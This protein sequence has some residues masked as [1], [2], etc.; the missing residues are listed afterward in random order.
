M[1]NSEAVCSSHADSRVRRRKYTQTSRSKSPSRPSQIRSVSPPRRRP[2]RERTPERQRGELNH[3]S[4][5]RRPKF[6][7]SK[8]LDERPRHLYQRKQ[9]EFHRQMS[10]FDLSKDSPP[11][12]GDNNKKSGKTFVKAAK[13]FFKDKLPGVPTISGNA[14]K[15]YSEIMLSRFRSDSSAISYQCERENLANVTGIKLSTVE[16]SSDGNQSFVDREEVDMDEE[17]IEST[18]SHELES[19]FGSHADRLSSVTFSQYQH[20]NDE[21][22]GDKDGDDSQDDNSNNDQTNKFA[23]ELVFLLDENESLR[24]NINGLRR[25]FESMLKRM[26]MIADGG[27]VC[28]DEQSIQT[29]DN[30]RVSVCLR[31]IDEMKIQALDKFKKVAEKR[32]CDKNEEFAKKEKDIESF[33]ECIEDLLCENERLFNNVVLL[34]KERETILKEVQCLRHEIKGKQDDVVNSAA[35]LMLTDEREAK[36]QNSYLD[37]ISVLLK[38][39]R[40]S[41]KENADPTEVENDIISL[42]AKIMTQ[43]HYLEKLNES[44]LPTVPEGCEQ[45]CSSR[46]AEG[47][48]EQYSAVIDDDDKREADDDDYISGAD[49]D[50]YISGADDDDYISGAEDDNHISGNSTCSDCKYDSSEYNEQCRE[51]YHEVSSDSL[52]DNKSPPF[53]PND[54]EDDSSE[55]L[56]VI[57]EYYSSASEASYYCEED[58]YYPPRRSSYSTADYS[59][60][61]EVSYMF[62]LYFY[63]AFPAVLANI[64]FFSLQSTICLRGHGQQV[65]Q[66]VPLHRE[67]GVPLQD[68]QGLLRDHDLCVEVITLLHLRFLLLLLKDL[69]RFIASLSRRTMRRLLEVSRVNKIIRTLKTLQETKR[70]LMQSIVT[71]IQRFSTSL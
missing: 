8:S 20:Q 68:E 57:Y 55:A 34:S 15:K 54:R 44:E 2:S 38:K 19:G 56:E 22:F 16:H 61:I 45:Q 28:D 35:S 59:D 23:K 66:G 32:L 4:S 6:V 58:G 14:C 27:E 50:S 47:Y 29:D 36:S 7:R 10:A 65:E 63:L 24:G 12:T 30:S 25:D 40:V 17:D 21:D 13:L 67:Q 62:E 1:P 46:R 3:A 42:V 69:H 49:D 11:P 48:D 18:R 60:D 53:F 41:S 26:Q 71:W 39:M 52:L 70:L 5:D 31:Q 9:K 64:F 37:N 51:E 43:Q 33:E